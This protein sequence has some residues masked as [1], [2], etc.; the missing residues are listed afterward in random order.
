MDHITNQLNHQTGKAYHPS[1]TAAMKL[2]CKKMDHYYLL[3]DS[4]TIYQIPM[5]LHP[6]M[7]LD[8]FCNQKWEGEWIEEAESLV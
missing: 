5:I 3:T 2:A 6:G 4:S 7:K 8:Y 1:L